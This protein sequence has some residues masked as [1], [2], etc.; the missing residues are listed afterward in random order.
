MHKLHGIGLGLI[1]VFRN[2]AVGLGLLLGG[3]L[4]LHWHYKHTTNQKV[5]YHMYIYIYII[6]V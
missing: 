6:T 4:G 2:C 5:R 1:T 3:L